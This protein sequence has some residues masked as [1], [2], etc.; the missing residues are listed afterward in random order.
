MEKQLQ[1]QHQQ[2][3]NLQK[4]AAATAG[5]SAPPP[6]NHQEIERLKKELQASNVE[7]ERFQA[8]LEMLVQELERSQVN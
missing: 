7:K 6:Q 5:P 1:Q 4:Q 8:Q 2:M 3:A